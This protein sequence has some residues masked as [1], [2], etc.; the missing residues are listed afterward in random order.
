M[1]Y[2]LG[3]PTDHVELIHEFGTATAVA[4]IA[5]KA[6]DLGYYGV[7]VTDHPAPPMSFIS[8]GGHHTLDPMVTLAT[9]ATSTSRLKVLTNLLIV[10]YRNPFLAAK[11][12]ATLDNLSEGR[13]ILGVG[14]GYLK[15]EFEAVG[16][17]FDSRG[18][19]LNEH[20]EVMRQA[21]T[22]EPVTTEGGDYFANN[23]VSLPRPAHHQGSLSIPIWVGGNSNNA[24]DR[25]VRFGE[26][27]IPMPTPKGID[28]FVHTS[29]INDLKDLEKKITKLME[30]WEQDG[31]TTTP[32]IAIA[33][34]D[35]GQHG[36]KNWNPHMYLERIEQL[37]LL[38]VTHIP[39]MLS[40]LGGRSSMARP[41]FLERVAAYAEFIDL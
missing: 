1:K 28:K 32:S 30:K 20:L 4:E 38:G 17:S 3:L 19:L 21:W 5:Q 22:G 39:I 36:E 9:A 18:D 6:E 23:I 31:R 34:W 10:G 14:A 37:S 41:Q 27:W 26:G 29:P 13:L 24:I 40:H 8:L 16:A 33:P 7:F 15:E 2:L 25:V 35:A 11:S 12:A